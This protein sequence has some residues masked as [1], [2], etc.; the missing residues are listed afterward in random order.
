MNF[1]EFF[2]YIGYTVVSILIFYLVAKSLHFQVRVIEGL[3]GMK[4]NKNNPQPLQEE[5][6]VDE[7]E[8]E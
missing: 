5:E 2:K 3:V 8:T 6:A 1:D 7:S 4:K